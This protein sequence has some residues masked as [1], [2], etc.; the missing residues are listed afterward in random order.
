MAAADVLEPVALLGAVVA[1]ASAADLIGDVGANRVEPL[2]QAGREVHEQLGGGLR[3]GHRAMRDDMLTT[4][5]ESHEVAEL[6]RP[7]IGVELVGQLERV[8]DRGRLPLHVVR[9][10][11]QQIRQV[12][13][14]V[15]G[16]D[17][18]V[19]DPLGEVR[20]H[21]GGRR[22][23]GD[24]VGVDA[25][26]LVSDDRAPGVDERLE[27]IDD[28]AVAHAERGDVDDV[29]VLR[30]HRGRLEIEDD[31][32][33]LALG[34]ALAELDDR[35]GL[36]T[37]ER[38]LLR[39]PGRGDELLLEVDRLLEL[40]VAVGDGIGHHVLGQDLRASLDHHHRF[41]RAG[42][43][44]VELALVE[45]AV[46]RVGDELA[47]DAADA[48]AADRAH[49]RDLAHAQRGRRPVQGDDVGVVLLVGRED[50]QDDLDVV[51]V[52]LREERA[53]RPVGEAHRQDG[54]LRW[55][56][57]ALDEAARDLAGGI[58]SLLVVDGERE[59]VRA[60]ARILAGDG[61]RQDDRVSVTE[62]DGAIGLLGE[63]AGLHAE[64]L[65]A[66]L[67]LVLNCH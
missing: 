40:R 53:D 35:V 13:A 34:E 26:D 28:L 30:L 24:V 7:R 57:L 48:H 18:C 9:E 44:E 17:R 37:D 3:V 31:E 60:L 19:A 32:L 12:E 15:V 43:D 21:L 62:N 10:V 6:P 51:V 63:L 41:T 67:G 64:D 36:R 14:D 33:G 11:A 55:A 5:D 58:H 22:R 59:E 49:E 66:D 61:C 46:G 27:A 29:A 47:T 65:A 20:E 25:V 52:A 2:G 4:E 54:R 1:L 50:R 23:I 38:L 45:L 8:E 42:D 39:L 56:R 16:H